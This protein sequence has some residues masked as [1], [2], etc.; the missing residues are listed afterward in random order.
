MLG[1]NKAKVRVREGGPVVGCQMMFAHP[2][3]VEHLGRVG[4]DW[5]LFDGEHGPVSPESIEIGV[6]AAENVGITPLARVP[7]NRPEV[8]LRF[9]DTGLAGV[10]VPHVD[11]AD[12]ARA[13]VRAVKYHPMGERGLAGVR[14]AG[15]GAMSQT[16]FVGHSNAQT[17]VLAMIESVN[18]IQN[19]E[20]IASV[21][22][23]DVLNIGTS[24]LS[25]SMGRPGKKDDP[26]LIEMVRR[27]IQVGKASGKAVA[28]GG[29]PS[30]DWERWRGEGVSWFGTSVAELLLSSG[31]RILTTMRGG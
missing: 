7:V 20:A 24:D 28:V 25:Q 12:D 4:F 21:E 10:L 11:S 27:V 17:M 14:A 9:M 29:V 13:A 8:I 26:E 6:L 31:R 30:T 2:Q 1:E 16:D 18:A 15:Y 23:L 19:I 3:V 5:V 22:G